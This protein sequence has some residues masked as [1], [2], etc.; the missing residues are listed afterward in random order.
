MLEA[1]AL[2]A[3]MGLYLRM[4]DDAKDLQR[5]RWVLGGSSAFLLT[6]PKQRYRSVSTQAPAEGKT[7]LSHA[8]LSHATPW[9][10]GIYPCG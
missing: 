8:P 7:L 3:G 9:L 2:K 1:V 6:S 10:F 5:V 4:E